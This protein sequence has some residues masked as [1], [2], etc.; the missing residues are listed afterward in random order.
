MQYAVV[1]VADET[2]F[3]PFASMQEAKDYLDGM[4]A[5]LSDDEE[6]NLLVFELRAP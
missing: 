2:V 6:S 4:A 1:D 3:G 5:E